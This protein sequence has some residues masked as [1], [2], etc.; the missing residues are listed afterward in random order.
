VEA[1]LRVTLILAAMAAAGLPIA[2]A[3]LA[4]VDVTADFSRVA[5]YPNLKSKLGLFSNVRQTSLPDAVPF[6]EDLGPGLMCSN[7]EFDYWYKWGGQDMPALSQSYEVPGDESSRP[8]EVE[9]QPG[10]WL[11]GYEERVGELDV[12]HLIQITGAPAQFQ[13]G[14]LRGQDIHPA[15]SDVAAAAEFMARWTDA[16]RHPYP[17]IWSLWNEPNHTLIPLDDAVT[18]MPAQAAGADGRLTRK[19][20]RAQLRA[21]RR[22]ERQASRGK[23]RKAVGGAE[24]APAILTESA[25]TIVAIYGAYAAAMR[26]TIGETSRLGLAS[27]I[28]ANFNLAKTT[29]AG[30]VYFDEVSDLLAEEFPEH[31]AD[32]LTFNSF[33]GAWPV[34]LS[35]VR[36]IASDTESQP[37][38]M[39]T[40]YAPRNLKVNADGEATKLS[41]KDASPM[42]AAVATLED[43]TALY[44]ATDVQ[45]VC[46]SYW[47]GGPYGM[48]RDSGR[49]LSP[50]PRY[51]AVRMLQAVPTLRVA[52]ETGSADVGGL[53][54]V[55]AAT[56]SVLLWNRSGRDVEVALE[57]SGLPASLEGADT[58][59]TLLDGDGEVAE[60]SLRGGVLNLPG[61]GVA[62][63][64]R[65]DPGADD[66]LDR[67][68][69]VAARFLQTRSFPDRVAERCEAE[70]RLPKVEG[71]ARNSGTYGFFDS[72]RAE[73]WLGQGESGEA[74]VTATYEGLPEVLYLAARTYG[75]G[76]SATGEG[77]DVTVAFDGCDATAAAEPA[78]DGS[79]RALDLSAVPVDCVAGAATLSFTL[80]G[81]PP[82][83]QAEVAL[84]NDAETAAALAAFRLAEGATTEAPDMDERLD[85]QPLGRDD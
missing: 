62:L 66:P 37:M 39:F 11:T 45:H 31:P 33:N 85:F 23:G 28:S 67:R 6:I 14:G 13:Q 63:V 38:I 49:Q 69:P 55:N 61:D 48:L 22:A 65:R 71:C 64:E 3:A 2:P 8:V 17:V 60:A 21:E 9:D 77:V 10:A 12:A 4:Q 54:G 81:V 15:P 70:R 47:I 19:E 80:A 40:Q 42:Q 52:L 27:F 51:E 5:F 44:R 46:L 58:T 72:V 74:R 7:I 82:G 36:A 78:G 56:A 79:Y 75:P 43:L 35:G 18:D 83:T 41:G 16:D 25:R 84:A 34:I 30:K 50:M 32:V 26:D 53:A 68:S 73:A 57:M 76:A 20:A 59:V 29:S 1:E 24:E